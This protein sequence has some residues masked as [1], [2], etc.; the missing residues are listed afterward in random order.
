MVTRSA[1]R[2]I[3]LDFVSKS[4]S[5]LS[6][7]NKKLVY[8]SKK[9]NKKGEIADVKDNKQMLTKN[10]DRKPNKLSLVWTRRS[11]RVSSEPMEWEPSLSDP[12]KGS[13]SWAVPDNHTVS[14]TLFKDPRTHE[15][16]D[17]DWTFVIED[18]RFHFLLQI[19]ISFL[20]KKVNKHFIFCQN[21]FLQVVNIV[22]LL[23]RILIW[24]SMPH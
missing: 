14:V 13:I 7:R 22:M 18:V 8:R 3:D 23:L 16:E 24:K 21:R 9:W 17:K 4:I 1:S 12:L 15:L 19:F 20:S 6:S 11:R 2:P 5:V 10:D